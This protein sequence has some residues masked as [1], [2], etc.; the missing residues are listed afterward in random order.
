MGA[1]A[2]FE[3]MERWQRIDAA[4]EPEARELLRTCCGASRWIDRM[5][6]RRPF[7][8]HEAAIRA[9][10]EEWF[11]LSPDD[12]IEAFNHHPR[13][14]DRDGLR[15]RF[16]AAR[17]LSEREQSGVSGASEEVLAGLIEGNREYESRFGYL[18]IVCATGKSAQEML[19]ILR[20]RLRNDP[21][22]EIGVAAEE[23]A[24]ICDL[25]LRI[26]G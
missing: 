5:L 15:T 20:K 7:G 8:G 21:D 14:G 11:A 2:A 4:S 23:H 12:W 19:T 10:R 16:A 1:S 25:R 18:F 9:A 17:E 6:T 24:K 13:I 26:Q 22:V 3:F